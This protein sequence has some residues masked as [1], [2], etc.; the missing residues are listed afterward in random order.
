MAK[1]DPNELCPCQSKFLFKDCHG[2][3]IRQPKIPEI[4]QS[5]ELKIIPEPDPDTRTLFI[6]EGEGTVCFSGYEI[7][8]ALI[9]GNCKSQLVVGIP[10][11]NIE[12]IV[13][14][15]KKCGKYNE[16]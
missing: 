11:A 8:L 6:Y 13:I 5:V 12:N 10:K 1:I 9:C 2:L 15:C 7:G 4:T 3:K 14:R 16:V